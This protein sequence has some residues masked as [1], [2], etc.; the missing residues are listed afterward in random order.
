RRAIGHDDVDPQPSQF[1]GCRRQARGIA[2]GGTRLECDGLSLDKSAFAKRIAERLPDRPVVDDADA[3]DLL[4]PLLRAGGA[5]NG[6]HA[7]QQCDEWARLDLRPDSHT[8]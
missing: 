6:G 1:S 8:G 7:P 5:R 2:V 3:W 4:L